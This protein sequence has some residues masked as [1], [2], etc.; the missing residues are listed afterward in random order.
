MNI[1][2]K[3]EYR[4]FQRRFSRQNETEEVKK[5]RKSANA[6]ATARKR[7]EETGAE[8]KKRNCAVNKGTAKKRKE[9]LQRAIKRAQT[10]PLSQYDARH[11]Q[12]V[13]FGEQILPELK[14]TKD[15]IGTMAAN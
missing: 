7:K 1:K 10:I 3:R 2:E 8:K 6:L 15:N 5:T 9:E 13:L 12:K 11:S 14:D 4:K